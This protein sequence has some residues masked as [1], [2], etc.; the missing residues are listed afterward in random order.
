MPV[1]EGEKFFLGYWDF[2]DDASPWSSASKSL[3]DGFLHAPEDLE[4]YA[5]NSM[6]PYLRPAIAQHSKRD[7]IPFR[8]L[9][10]SIFQRDF[11]CPTGTHD[12][13]SIGQDNLCCDTGETCVSTSDGLG[14]CPAGASCGNHVSDCDTA[15]GYTSCPNSPNGGC[16]IP[17]AVCKGV[18]CIFQGTQTVT[19][20]AATAT[21]T[22]GVSYTTETSS[23]RTVTVEVP[24]TE[25]STTTVTLSPNGYTTTQTL[26][27]S[28]TATS[29]RNGYFSCPQS[30]GGGCCPNGQACGSDGSCPDLT[31]STS[32]TA[33]Q[34]VLP[35]SVSPDTISSS[36]ST[37]TTE[38]NCPTGFYQCSA[39]Y[40][41]GCCRVGRN[42]ETTSCPPE[43]ST[44]LVSSG[45][46]VVVTGNGNAEAT[47]GT[48]ANGWFLCGAT[49]GGGCCP[50]G[51][52]CGQ[53]SCTAPNQGQQNT[54]K[55]APSS[56][57]VVGWAWSFLVLGLVAGAGMVVL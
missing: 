43:D 48:C 57:N 17:G 9:G 40:L 10:R 20:T 19:R 51:Y 28:G 4:P 39:R 36:T 5:N 37:T 6:T 30:D 29:C 8:I 22:S 49:G 12:C 16:C 56:A 31:T 3:E 33:N 15:D 2:G 27:I 53:V 1:D 55:M 32:A 14:C 46:T 23:G 47:G 35:T 38:G 50:S 24:T 45:V 54:L 26:I 18:G 7:R 13:S 25:V 11:Q 21:E 34:P 42:C 41:G 44:T 52:Q